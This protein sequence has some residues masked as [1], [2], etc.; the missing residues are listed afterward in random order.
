MPPGPLGTAT[1]RSV[2]RRRADGSGSEERLWDPKAH[3]HVDDWTPDGRALL[4]ATSDPSGGQ[5]DIFLLRIDGGDRNP[6]PLLQT[7]FNERGARVSRDG[8]W[9]AYYSNESGRDEVYVRSF[10]S[11]NGKWQLSVGGGSE[12]VWS[13]DGKELFY[14]AAA[15]VAVSVTS[16]HTFSFGPPRPLFRDRFVLSV[17]GNHTGFDVSKDGKRFVMVKA[18]ESTGSAPANLVIVQNWVK[19][20]KDL[21]PVE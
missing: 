5:G 1:T 18:G 2:F 21:L 9:V 7:P 10:P 6:V 14:R 19:E 12:P 17:S 16:S 8:R 4:V 20:L 3:V 15:L 11:L 13:H